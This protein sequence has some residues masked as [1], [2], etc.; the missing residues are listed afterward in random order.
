MAYKYAIALTGGIAS[1]KSTV[2]NLFRLY[3]LRIIDADVIARQILDG[4]SQTIAELFGKEYV[5]D[6]KVD[7][8][9]FGGLIFSDNSARKR[10]EEFLHPKIKEEIKRQSKEQDRLKGPYI[11]DIPLFYETNNYPIKKVI[12]VY[13]PREIQKNR[14]INREGL[15]SKEA[16][17]RLNAQIDIEKKKRLATWVIDNS[18]NLKHLQ[19]ETE[20]IL[21]KIVK[22]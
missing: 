12:V 6:G 2:C 15:S 5:V 3:G 10:L 21:S 17:D 7:R 13:A 8:K 22:K 1:G 9:A 18:K 4:K 14:L 11:V 20:H 19:Q 16:E